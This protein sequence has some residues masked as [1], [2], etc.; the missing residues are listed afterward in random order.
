[1]N[2]AWRARLRVFSAGDCS[3]AHAAQNKTAEPGTPHF[4]SFIASAFIPV[5][6]AGDAAN[7]A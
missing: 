3:T 5:M 6:I 2:P 1:V 4:G 7:P